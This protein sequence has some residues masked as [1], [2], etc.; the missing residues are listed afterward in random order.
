MNR[1]ILHDRGSGQWWIYAA[2]RV[3]AIIIPYGD[4]WRVLKGNNIATFRQEDMAWAYARH[5]LDR[6]DSQTEA[7]CDEE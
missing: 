1:T 5:P 7:E 6:D 3:H 2:G 4:S